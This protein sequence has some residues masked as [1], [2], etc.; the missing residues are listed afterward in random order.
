MT[1]EERDLLRKA[2]EM[3]EGDAR[4]FLPQL[5]GMMATPGCKCG[6]PS[7]DLHL[8]FGA[9]AV[10]NCTQQIVSDLVGKTEKDELI[11][12]ILFQED[13]KLNELEVY[14]VDGEIQAENWG[15]PRLAT[16]KRY[17]DLVAQ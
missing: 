17:Q 3:G 10:R 1:R 4:L 15:L 12:L 14:S 11:G 6:C 13:G 8:R 16:L 2:I 5:E 9:P 7:I